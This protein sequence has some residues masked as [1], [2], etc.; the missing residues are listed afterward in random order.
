MERHKMKYL[1]GI[2]NIFGTQTV[3][4]FKEIIER[5][6]KFIR[7]SY[8]E[9]TDWIKSQEFVEMI[10][11]DSVFILGFFIQIG[12]QKFNRNEDVL[13]EE[14]CLLTTIFEDLTLLENQLP[15]ALLEELFEPFLFSLKTEETFRDLTL[16]VFGF[17]NKIE[18][19]VKFRHF[20]DLFRRVRVATLGLTEEQASNAKAEPPKSIKSLHNADKL[21]SAGVDFENVDKEND[22]SLVI[23]FKDG[24]LKMPC[25]TAEDNTERVMRNL[26]ALEQ[27]HYPLSAYVC[28]YIAFLDFLIDTEQDVNLLFKKGIKTLVLCKYLAQKL[29]NFVIPNKISTFDVK[30]SSKELDGTS[31]IGGGHGKQA[32]FRARRFW[33]SLSTNS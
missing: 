23:D 1:D 30:R 31:R 13:F 17:E 20:T 7:E 21:D 28:N 19:D 4:E 5:D 6:E 18:R 10:L 24:V 32:V 2:A 14:P 11:H 22:L 3:E 25:F 16:R 27:C 8:S 29:I 12:T 9:S 33:I 15:Y 26:M